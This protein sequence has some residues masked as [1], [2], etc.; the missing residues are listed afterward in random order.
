ME[1]NLIQN[2][3][4]RKFQIFWMPIKQGVGNKVLGSK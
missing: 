4:Y 2:K 3:V 1:K